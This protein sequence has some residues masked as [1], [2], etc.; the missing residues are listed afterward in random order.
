MSCVSSSVH[1]A[2]RAGVYRS[3]RL[4]ANIARCLIYG[5]S[6]STAFGDLD[7]FAAPSW[8]FSHFDSSAFVDIEGHDSICPA[9][10]RGYAPTYL[11][12]CR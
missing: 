6:T 10:L 9:V 7:A 12:T 5:A 11:K 1:S 3:P 4:A 2:V 8:L